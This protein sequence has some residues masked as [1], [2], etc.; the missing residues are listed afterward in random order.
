MQSETE[1]KE[2]QSVKDEQLSHVEDVQFYDPWNERLKLYF[3]PSPTEFE[4]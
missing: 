1:D 3:S 4:F 2:Y